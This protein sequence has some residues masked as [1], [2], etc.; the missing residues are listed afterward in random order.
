MTGDAAN[1][2]NVWAPMTSPTIPIPSP[3]LRT[4]TGVIVMISTIT[5]WPTTSVMI[6]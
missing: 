3:A 6:A 4:C 1:I 2:P 5:T